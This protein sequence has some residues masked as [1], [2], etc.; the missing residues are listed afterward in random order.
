VGEGH[1]RPASLGLGGK[2]AQGFPALP[3]T[4]RATAPPP[5]LVGERVGR[6]LPRPFKQGRLGVAR[7]T[8]LAWSSRCGRPHVA[9]SSGRVLKPCGMA[10]AALLGPT[11]E[12]HVTCVC[13]HRLRE[14]MAPS[15]QREAES[16]PVPI[17]VRVGLV[18]PSPPP[19]PHP[20]TGL[21]EPPGTPLHNHPSGPLP[22][23]GYY[24]VGSAAHGAV[25]HPRTWS[26]AH[27]IAVECCGILVAVAHA[28]R[29]VAG[30]RA[31]RVCI[32]C[33]SPVAGVPFSRRKVPSRA[34]GPGAVCASAWSSHPPTPTLQQCRLRRWRYGRRATCILPSTEVKSK[35]R[36]PSGKD[37][38]S[39]GRS[40]LWG[41]GRRRRA[42]PS[43][44]LRS[45][46]RECS[47]PSMH[48]RSRFPWSVTSCGVEIRGCFPSPDGPPCMSTNGCFSAGGGEAAAIIVTARLRHLAAGGSSTAMSGTHAG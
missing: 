38:H 20:P 18:P 35:E 23:R 37:A 7:E 22:G 15:A 28:R 39:G 31:L 3:P 33:I 29:S 17:L 48:D 11:V 26:S 42:R 21:E 9:A 41:L 40:T 34:E 46:H 32:R 4:L 13:P 27:D 43:F 45:P 44:V 36:F 24:G 47:L 10:S 1:L 19:L 2:N 16:V 14:R 25:L 5:R 12:V 30:E 8:S 6:L